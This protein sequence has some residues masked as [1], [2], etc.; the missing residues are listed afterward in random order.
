MLDTVTVY[1]DPY[2]VVLVISAWNYPVQLSLLPLGSAIAAGNCVI[3]KTSELAPACAK[4][5][6]DVLPKYLD[7]VSSF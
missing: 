5:L 4:F 3:V 2:G 1:K 7:T 6:A